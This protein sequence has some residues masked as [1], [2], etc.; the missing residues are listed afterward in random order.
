[1]SE[2]TGAERGSRDLG[3]PF[4]FQEGWGR[5]ET[6]ETE[7]EGGGVGLTFKESVFFFFHFEFKNK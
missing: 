1:M 3:P 4:F 5:K 2:H 6:M 7:M